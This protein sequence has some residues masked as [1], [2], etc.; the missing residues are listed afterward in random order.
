MLSLSLFN[1]LI[2]FLILPADW[3]RVQ[4]KGRCCDRKDFR[5]NWWEQSVFQAKFSAE[6]TLTVFF[7]KCVT[8]SWFSRKLIVFCLNLLVCP[9]VVRQMCSLKTWKL[10][11]HRS[12]QSFGSIFKDLCNTKRLARHFYSV[13]Y[14]V[15][16]SF[17]EMPLQP[18]ICS[19]KSICSS[20][21]LLKIFHLNFL[22]LIHGERLIDPGLNFRHDRSR[23][24]S[25]PV[26]Y[27]TYQKIAFFA[28]STSVG[29]QTWISIESFDKKS[30]DWFSGRKK[31]GRLELGFQVQ[32]SPKLIHLN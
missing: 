14:S 25:L 1:F 6:P 5:Q 21:N 13:S 20:S 22:C 4:L 31:F 12:W 19:T 10:I 8:R 7:L 24:E 30:V 16:S 29:N 17:F 2:L 3:D 15:D 11:S 32:A 18:L 9:F 27:K 23:C 26:F 28:F